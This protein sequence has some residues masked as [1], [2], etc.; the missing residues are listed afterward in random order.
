MR[1]IT[2]DEAVIGKRIR[3]ARL[4][5]GLSQEKLGEVLGLTFQQVQKYEKGANRVS[6]SRLRTVA[7]ALDV[8]IGSLLGEGAHQPVHDDV[9]TAL[10]TP[11]GHA[12]AASFNMLPAEKRRLLVDVAKAMVPS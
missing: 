9:I 5:R 4:A 1:R 2:D 11:G 10:S 3:A 8:S 7:R 12:L 6:G